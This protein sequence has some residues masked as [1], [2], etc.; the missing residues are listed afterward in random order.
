[1]F[2]LLFLPFAN[3]IYGRKIVATDEKTLSAPTVNGVS[4][5]GE[6]N[7]LRTMSELAEFNEVSE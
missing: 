2:S 3:F 7:E 6:L 5:V 4:R 1:V